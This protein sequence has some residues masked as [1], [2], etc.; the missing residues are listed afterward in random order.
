MSGTSL[1]GLDLC[2]AEFTRE[3]NRWAFNILSSET[4]KYSPEW[5]HKLKT[6]HTLK[7]GELENLDKELSA[8]I[9]QKVHDH[10]QTNHITD[11]ELVGSHGHTVFHQPE[12]GYTLQ[13]GNRPEIREAAGLPVVCDFR[14]ADVELGGQG[15]PLVP[16]GDALLFS[17][18]DVCL[19]LGGF[20]N[21]SLEENGLRTAWDI[22][23]M[24]IGLNYF[25]NKLGLEYDKGGHIAASNP[26]DGRVWHALNQL[27]FYSSEPPKSLGREWFENEI[28]P[29]CDRLTPEES[30]ATLSGH[31]AV[32]IAK[33]L[34]EIGAQK[35]LCTG[36]GAYNKHIMSLIGQSISGELIVPD[37]EIV[38]YKEALLFGFLGLLKSLG[39]INVL[40]S[41]T[42]A[43]QDH[44]SGVIFE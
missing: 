13:I 43:R 25:A 27:P 21:L 40:A 17:D 41:V 5:Q 33:T 7:E 39:E 16:I 10:L 4:V 2:V 23:P 29:R 19:N 32:Q 12:K 30:L 11:V 44:S 20:A 9:G 8:Y 6:A 38:E 37:K 34:Q 28:I 24:N 22:C 36:G 1:D 18:Y 14:K 15:A 3:G 42:G 26:M 35:V 31:A